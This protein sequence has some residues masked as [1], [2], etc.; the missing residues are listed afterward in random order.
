MPAK[1]VHRL[2]EL[3]LLGQTHEASEAELNELNTLLRGDQRLRELAVESLGMDSMLVEA[4]EGRVCSAASRRQSSLPGSRKIAKRAIWRIGLAVAVALAVGVGWLHHSPQNRSLQNRPAGKPKQDPQAAIHSSASESSEPTLQNLTQLDVTPLPGGNDFGTVT[5][6]EGAEWLPSKSVGDHVGEGPLV[7][8]SGIGRIHLRRG[9]ELLIDARRAIAK[10]HFHLDGTVSVTQGD[11]IANVTES[12]L[13]FIIRTPS[14]KIVDIG[15]RFAVSVDSAGRSEV[16]VIDGAVSC[17]P[18]DADAI[19]NESML[20]AGQTF[21]FQG[22]TD[23]R[24]QMIDQPSLRFDDLETL[25]DKWD[26]ARPQGELICYEGFDY[27]PGLLRR[28]DAGQGWTGPWHPHTDESKQPV[29]VIRQGQYLSGLPWLISRS[30]TYCVAPSASVSAR[31]L[32][33]PISLDVDRDVF[34]SF[35]MRRQR[36]GPHGQTGGGAGIS[37]H[38]TKDLRPEVGHLGSEHLVFALS[39]DMNDNLT[40]S[41]GT[42]RYNG[43]V[44]L[45]NSGNYFVVVKLMLRQSGPDNLVAKIFTQ[46]D[47]PQI[48][49]PPQ[50]DSEGHPFHHQGYLRKLQFWCG[51]DAVAAFDELRIGTTWES[52]VPL[53]H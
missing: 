18:I 32:A 49:E 40:A 34:V 29:A 37:W 42:G 3:L 21:R 27:P 4:F 41:T 23:Q 6:A 16:Q 11:V 30:K 45:R 43:G 46:D 9:A 47:A 19:R 7:L 12:A 8:T 48:T 28:T 22:P 26:S 24:G 52:V 44:K 31:L 17:L 51:A 38:A 33:D 53:R 5:L 39:A 35:L 15:T 10:M 36:L 1:S 13:G 50:W 25:R 14:T 2:E 20:S